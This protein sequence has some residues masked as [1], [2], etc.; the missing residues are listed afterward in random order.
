M[1]TR[2]GRGRA[3]RGRWKMPVI[4]SGSRGGNGGPAGPNGKKGAC[5]G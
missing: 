3:R 2:E 1:T 5:K 4:S